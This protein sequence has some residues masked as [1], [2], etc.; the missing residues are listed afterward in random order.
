[1]KGTYLMPSNEYH[2]SSENTPK[3]TTRHRRRGKKL[4]ADILASTLELI[5]QTKYEDLTMD[6]IAKHAHTNKS[7]LYRRWD[8]K[9]EI[10][11]AAIQTKADSLFSI[12]QKVPDT[13]SL[14][15]D[16]R[17][18]FNNIT[19]L[20]MEVHYNHISGLMHERLGGI[21]IRDFFDKFARKNLLSQ[22][23]R[24]FFENAEKRGEVNLVD[25]DPALYDLPMLML[26][27]ALYAPHSDEFDS[28]YFDHIVSDILMPIYRPFLRL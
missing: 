27:E 19:A 4:E 11:V 9:A 18:L 10:V 28:E 24:T 5:E 22:M 14:E 15:G 17:E 12:F 21:S 25:I 23:V 8:S 13:D 26:F 2:D 3:S 7:V 20:F 16:L 1:M 6:I